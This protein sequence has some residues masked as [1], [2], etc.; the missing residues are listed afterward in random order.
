MKGTKP[1]QG[2]RIN[3]TKYQIFRSL[4]DEHSTC[5]SVHGK[6]VLK[7]YNSTTVI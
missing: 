3:E 4:V 5:Y 7:F 6:K 2:L 1:S